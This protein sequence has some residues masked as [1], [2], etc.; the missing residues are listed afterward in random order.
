MLVRYE[1]LR[2]DP[3]T[4]IAAI[5]EWLDLD[6]R[7]MVELAAGSTPDQIEGKTRE[8]FVRSGTPGG[9]ASISRP[10]SRPG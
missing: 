2:Q 3:E 8:T 4:V 10:P 9:G 6:P 5:A 7:P 1:E